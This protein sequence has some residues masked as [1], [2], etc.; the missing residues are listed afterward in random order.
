[1]TPPSQTPV[2]YL[3]KHSLSAS[4]AANILGQIVLHIDDPTFEFV[5]TS[6]VACL[7]PDVFKTFLQEPHHDEDALYTAASSKD[8]SLLASVRSLFSMSSSREEDGSVELG[9]ERITIRRLK[10]DMEYFKELKKNPDV[11]RKLLEMCPVGKKIYLVV[12][13]MGFQS[14]SLKRTGMQ[15]HESKAAGSLPT[16]AAIAALSGGTIAFGEA[17]TVEV[18]GGHARS[19]EWTIES[20]VAACDAEDGDKSDVVFAVS[21]RV[22]TRNW[23][24]LGSDIKMKIKAEQRSGLHFG[25]RDSEEDSDEESDDEEAEIQAAEGFEWLD[26][27]QV[28]VVAG[29][30]QSVAFESPA[31]IVKFN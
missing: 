15:R 11:R 23:K 13:T 2:F 21:Y 22:I 8:Q 9:S 18:S 3:L 14:A 6:P 16:G 1:M 4:E 10:R 12:G 7:G 28:D 17:G 31:G 27:D 25:A 19:A 30:D 20:K 5:P 26:A 29:S 24:R